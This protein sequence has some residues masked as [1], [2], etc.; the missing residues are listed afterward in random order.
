MERYG[1]DT[2]HLSADRGICSTIS[3]YGLLAEHQD[4]TAAFSADRDLYITA[5][6]T[7]DRGIYSTID[8]FYRMNGAFT[9]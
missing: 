2:E 4:I 5:D 1:A 6:F 8:S 7:A 9:A 3:N